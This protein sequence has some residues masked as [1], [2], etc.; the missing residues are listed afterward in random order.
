M[1]KPEQPASTG[2]GP[3][4]ERRYYID[5]DQPAL[6]AQQLME[7]I[8]CNVAHY[9]PDLLAQFEKVKGQEQ[10][11][12]QGDEFSIKIL[13]PWNGSVRVTEVTEDC[14]EFVTL[15]DHPEAGRIRFSVGPA[16]R[17][18]DTL[19]FEI[20]SWARSRD[21]LVA[22]T[23]DT[24]GMGKKVQQQTWELFCQKVAQASGGHAHG[25][26]QVETIEHDKDS[27]QAHAHA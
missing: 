12:R 9:S 24:L 1:T 8:Q 27:E 3:L 23:Y 21:G 6:S 5:I 20:H 10:R 2:S 19:R 25:P 4:F 22:F 17:R 14:F 13:G 16:G 18:H 7:A 26:V 15:E 11:L